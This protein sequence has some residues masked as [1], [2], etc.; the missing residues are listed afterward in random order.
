MSK[1][2]FLVHKISHSK[3]AQITPLDDDDTQQSSRTVLPH[4]RDAYRQLTQGTAK[5]KIYGS[6]VDN[7]MMKIKNERGTLS[8]L[9]RDKRFRCYSLFE[10]ILT[11]S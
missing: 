8:Q 1:S 7:I 9:N 3:L 6:D 5:N 11:L 4:S 2:L 10:P